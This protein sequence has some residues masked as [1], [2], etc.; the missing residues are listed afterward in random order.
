MEFFSDIIFSVAL[1]SWGQLSLNRIVS[2][3]FPVAK[4]GRS[5]GL[6]ALPPSCALVMKSGNLNFLERSA[7]NQSSNVTA[8]P[9]L[10]YSSLSVIPITVNTDNF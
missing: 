10:Q 1:L 2:G 7:A 9:F 3:V 6:A 8:V 5:V 4:G